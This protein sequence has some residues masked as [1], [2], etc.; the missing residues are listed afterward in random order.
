[1]QTIAHFLSF[2]SA[3]SETSNIPFPCH[4]L[5]INSSVCAL[6]CSIATT[7]TCYSSLPPLYPYSLAM[8]RRPAAPLSPTENIPLHARPSTE[9][10]YQIR[11]DPM[12]AGN[13]YAA[14]GSPGYEKKKRNKWLW[15]GLPILILIIIGAVLGGV[16]GT[17]LGGDDNKGSNNAS[18]GNSNTDANTGL[19]SGVTSINTATSTGANGQRYLA[20]A[21]DSNYLPVYATGVSAR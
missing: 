5:S 18:N 4:P 1:M 16:L 8:Y 14:G 7:L 3:L 12:S 13:A 6:V 21:T 10:P 11:P 19:P 15:I 20:V 17:Q 9:N 2:K